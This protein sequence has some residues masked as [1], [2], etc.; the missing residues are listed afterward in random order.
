MQTTFPV[1]S[2]QKKP[3]TKPCVDIVPF[4]VSASTEKKK[5]FFFSFPSGFHPPPLFIE[6]ERE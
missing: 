4:Q 2:K 5:D 6:I 3:F 1:L